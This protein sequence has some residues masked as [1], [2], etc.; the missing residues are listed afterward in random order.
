[1]RRRELIAGLVGTAAAW[2][3]AGHTQESTNR[4]IAVWLARPDNLE[5]QRLFTAFR[6]RLQVLGWADGQNI[7]IDYHWVV[8]DIDRVR[9]V[10][11]VIA[12]Q[13][14]EVILV[15]S[16]LGVATLSRENRTVPIVFVNVSDPIGSGFVA[17]LSRPGGAIT[18]FISNEP[19]LGGK[20]VELIKEIAPMI[21][22]VALMFNPDTAPY[23][24]EFV[25]YAKAAAGFSRIEFRA[26]Q[27][28]NDAEIEQAISA[29][30]GEPLG[31]LIALPDATVNARPDLIIG[32]AAR[33]RVP[34]IYA[35]GTQASGGGLMSYGVD[36]ADE[37]RSAAV[38]VD[39]ILR[40]S[41]PADL[42]VQ[43][44]ARF[45]TVLNLKNANALGLTVP[46]ATLLRAD[47]V[48]N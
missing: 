38:Y 42:P 32:L 39:R 21:R 16:T 44:P 13:H 37:S 4:K 28:H 7:R 14:P 19:T 23:A 43:A 27:I 36:L 1:M 2:P 47:E 34:A 3:L 12:E 22:R 18:G 5:G 35:F 6:Q 30:A 20:W 41:K 11:K 33:Y 45:V 17:S 9:N 26:A 46:L 29:L 8:G 48:I 10:A 40:G 15:E 24:D 25:R 31:G